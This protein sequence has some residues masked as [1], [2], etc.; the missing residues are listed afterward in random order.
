MELDRGRADGEPFG[1]FFVGKALYHQGKPFPF[2]LGEV[3][4][5]LLSLRS[6]Q[7][8]DEHLSGFQVKAGTHGD[9]AAD[10]RGEFIGGD[11]L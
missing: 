3:G 6:R 1:N 10:G 5:A 11:V 8:V 9:G 4:V 7:L 2:A